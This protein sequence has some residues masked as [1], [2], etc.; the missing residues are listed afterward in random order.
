MLEGAEIFFRCDP[1]FI[2]AEN[3]TAVCGPDG[4]W[5]PDPARLVCIC[6][7][8]KAMQCNIISS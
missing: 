7:I 3:M 6:K 2:P 5:N 4:R 8:I 1:G